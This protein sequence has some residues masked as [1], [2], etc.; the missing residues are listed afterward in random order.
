MYS[1][2]RSGSL[3]ST[4]TS[5]TAPWSPGHTPFGA[6]KG[7]SLSWLGGL[8][9]PVGMPRTKARGHPGGQVSGIRREPDEEAPRGVGFG[10]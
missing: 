2:R 1:T 7:P 4:K 8:A 10:L 9:P 6:G 3:R 5:S